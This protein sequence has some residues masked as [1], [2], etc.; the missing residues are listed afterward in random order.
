MF[1]SVM[2]NDD[3]IVIFSVLTY[4]S[5]WVRART[6]NDRRKHHCMS[7]TKFYIKFKVPLHASVFYDSIRYF[8]NIGK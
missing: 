5:A 3:F 7:A 6:T 2:H 1:E 8:N 4:D